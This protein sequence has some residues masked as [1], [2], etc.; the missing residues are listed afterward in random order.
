MDLQTLMSVSMMRGLCMMHK[1]VT[2]RALVL[3]CLLMIVFV[4]PSVA[5]V[6][7][8][9][10]VSHWPITEL[11]SASSKNYRKAARGANN[12]EYI[13]IH[14]VQGSLESAVYTFQSNKLSNPRS[15][16]FTVGKDGRVVKSVQPQDIAWH[17]GTSPI[18][19]GRGHESRVLNSNSIGIEHEGFVSEQDFPTIRQYVATSALVRTL[20]SQYGIPIDREHIVGHDEIKATKSDP[21]PNWDWPFFIQLVKHGSRRL[22]VSDADENVI[23]TPL[24]L[25]LSELVL[26]VAVGGYFVQLIR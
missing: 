12:I 6:P 3:S 5:D 19:S 25:R 8:D 4:L 14:T 9:V 18:G 1:R 13:V 7:Y 21:G 26:A 20:C 23:S 22:L 17:T 16:H 10:D 24:L 15:A 11:C 2:R